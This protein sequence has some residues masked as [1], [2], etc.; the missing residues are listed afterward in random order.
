M[1]PIYPLH[2]EHIN[3]FCGMPVCAVTRDGRRHAGILSRCE[4]GRL[5]FNERV[6]QQHASAGLQSTLMQTPQTSQKKGKSS[7]TKIKTEAAAPK[8]QTQAFTPYDP[9]YG[10]G[11]FGGSFF[12]DLAFLAFLFLLI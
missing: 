8:A 11:P 1:N 5:F 2:E 4:D 12:I 10:Y 7:K 3:R 6:G 9:Y